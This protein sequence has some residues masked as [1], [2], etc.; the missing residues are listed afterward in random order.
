VVHT[1]TLKQMNADIMGRITDIS[2][3]FT[4]NQ[5]AIHRLMDIEQQAMRELHKNDSGRGHQ[6]SCLH[7]HDGTLALGM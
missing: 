7:R 1:I 6:G 5:A 2:L 4:A 3:E